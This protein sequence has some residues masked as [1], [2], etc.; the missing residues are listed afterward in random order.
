ME[1]SKSIALPQEINSF[2]IIHQFRI[3]Q[4][5]CHAI[6]RLFVVLAKVGIVVLS[7]AV[8]KIKS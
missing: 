3:K 5:E 7:F 6:L 4:G 2:V 8:I 1:G